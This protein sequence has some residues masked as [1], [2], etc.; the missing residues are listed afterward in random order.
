MRIYSTPQT[1]I[2]LTSYVLSH[3]FKK[4]SLLDPLIYSYIYEC[5][6]TNYL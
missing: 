5:M 3:S 1:S 6:E 4:L 2:T